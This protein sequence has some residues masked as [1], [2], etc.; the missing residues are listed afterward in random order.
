MLFEA[1]LRQGIH[2]G[3]I[4]IAFRRW[5][6]A[7]VV[8]GGRYWTGQD[9]IE[10]GAVDVVT[11]AQISS[12]DAHKAGYPTATALLADLR[13][14]TGQSIF[15]ISFRRLDEPNPS[16]A[17]A[18]D[19]ALTE[20]DLAEIRARL[21]RLD[22]ASQ[23]GEWTAD[24]LSLI[25]RSPGVAASVLAQSIGLPTDVLKRDVRKLKALGL[26]ISLDTGYRL[27]PRAAAY[28]ASGRS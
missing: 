25:A 16:A 21:A 4:T 3:S 8:A 2:D 18:A 15:R 26:T 28:R 6:R 24:V 5:R 20:T 7:Q 19:D 23:R 17:L 10:V 13:G 1:R 22:H 9:M 12:G 11:P 14:A 27:S